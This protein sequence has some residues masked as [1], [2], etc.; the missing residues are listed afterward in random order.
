MKLTLIPAALDCLRKGSA[1]AN[2]CDWGRPVCPLGFGKRALS[3]G[4]EKPS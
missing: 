2:H 3:L 4:K 1:V